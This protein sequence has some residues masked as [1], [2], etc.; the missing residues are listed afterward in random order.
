MAYNPTSKGEYSVSDD[1]GT[2]FQRI[3][4]VTSFSISGGD[5][6]E[7]TTDTLDEGST[8]STGPARPKDV[9]IQC[10][11]NPG[12]AGY[13]ILFN[14]YTEAS[15]V[16]I[17]VKTDHDVIN[18]NSAA[19]TKVAIATTGTVTGTATKFKTGTE[20]KIGRG[21]QAGNSIY[22]IEKIN[23]ETELLVS[24]KPGTAVSA[25]ADWELVDF[26]V[27]WQFEAEVLSAGNV[28]ASPGSPMSD[29]FTIKQTGSPSLPTLVAT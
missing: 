13:K 18:D 10:N 5:R 24:P 28:D 14:A 20:W 23:S 21:L 1:G 9:S 6:E 12:S 22:V 4:N 8:V 19:G 16:T 26:G 29:T 17:R 7:E 3:Y 25:T 2:T 11:M 15:K 27:Q